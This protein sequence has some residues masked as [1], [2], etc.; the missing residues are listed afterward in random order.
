MA[1]MVET[2]AYAGEVPWHGLGNKVEDTLTPTEMLEAAGLD[3]TVSRRAMFTTQEPGT[4]QTEGTLTTSDYGVL[5][6]D[7]DNKI[8]GPC[9]K[10]YIPVQNE[11]VFSFFDKFVKAGDMTMGTAGSLNGGK[12]V[13]GLAN[14]RQGFT[15]PGGDEVQGHLLIS[16]PHEWGKSL[17]IMF[18]PVRVVCNNTLTMALG[19]EGQRFRMPHI[20]EFDMDVQQAAEEALGLASTQ[21]EAF[22]Q[23][24]NLL[25]GV[26]YKD[27]QFD[28]FMAQL[29][30]PQ[31]IN[32]AANDEPLDKTLFN[33]TVNQVHELVRTQPVANMS[34]G[35]WWSALNAV[36]YY[37]DHKAGRNRDSS[38]SNAWFGPRAALKRRALQLATEYAEAA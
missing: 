36:T 37:V 38:L 21:L 35:S 13:W 27:D 18:T 23:Q 4:N 33:R 19:M 2:M 24:S 26:Q 14:I 17:T 6:R 11:Q 31:L 29:F 3:W 10:N 1:H 34:E 8:L 16:H 12:Q 25:A 7:S 30:Q 32:L 9:G 20:R 5:V 22:E 15:L 28:R